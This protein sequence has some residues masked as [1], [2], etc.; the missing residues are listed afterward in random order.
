MISSPIVREYV[1]TG[2]SEV[3]PIIDMHGHIGHFYG[4]YLPSAPLERMI[5]SLKRHGVKRIVC[6][7]HQALAYDTKGGNA[8]MQRTIDDYPEHF[9][10]YWVANPNQ[11]ERMKEDIERF[12]ET[13]GFVGF[14]FW[15]DYHLIPITSP[16]YGP[17]LEYANDRGLLQKVHTFGGSPFNSPEMLGAIAEKNPRANF[18]MA[19]CGYGDWETSMRVARDFPNVYLDLTSAIQSIDF[20]L[21]PGG[22]FM[23][24]A[25]THSPMVNGIIE[26]M[27]A[28]SGSDKMVFG[29]DLPWYSQAYHAG[30]ILFAEISDEDRHRI[31]HGNAERLLHRWLGQVGAHVGRG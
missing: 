2:R 29:S 7:S 17:V 16:K 12:E 10:G 28:I 30:A 31:L 18:L 13:R 20:A 14:K 25:S 3:C 6:S 21:M 4:A 1:E 24:G 15:A 27:V 11:P 22:S 5:S 9:L 19:H 26:E 8:E 23:A